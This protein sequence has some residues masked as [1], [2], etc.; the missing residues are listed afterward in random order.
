MTTTTTTTTTTNSSPLQTLPHELRTA[1]YTHLF[2][3]LHLSLRRSKSRAPNHDPT[4]TPWQ[5]LFT[6]R[7][8]WTED[9]PTFYALSTITLEHAMFLHVLK[10]RI[11]PKNLSLVRNLE[12]RNQDMKLGGPDGAR[13]PPQL[14]TLVL[15][16][17][18]EMIEF[19][20]WVC[21]HDLDDEV[22]RARLHQHQARSRFVLNGNLREMWEKN[23][24]MKIFLWVD[25]LRRIDKKVSFLFSPQIGL[26]VMNKLSSDISTK[27]ITRSSRGSFAYVCSSQK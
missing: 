25:L 3:D 6:C 24:Q 7:R 4:R 13:L 10:H 27:K 15:W 21:L 2:H 9:L 22:L 1:I 12:L 17:T 18:N 19:R 16:D 23:S 14:K 26:T 5:I 8:F 11:T 20:S